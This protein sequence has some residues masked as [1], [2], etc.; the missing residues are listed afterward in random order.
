MRNKKIIKLLI[1]FMMSAFSLLGCESKKENALTFEDLQ[2]INLSEPTKAEDMFT[3]VNEDDDMK[4]I[5]SSI[6]SK[7]KRASVQSVNDTP[8]GVDYYIKMDFEY[9]NGEV[10]TCF[11]YNE[12]DKYFIEMPYVGVWRLP[13]SVYLNVQGYM[14][15]KLSIIG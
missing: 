12:K 11:V 4:N 14:A 3:T 2:E 8:T 10:L 6:K 13:K 7:A 15:S 5:I 9:K 1:V